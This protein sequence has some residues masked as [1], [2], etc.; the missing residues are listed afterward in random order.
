MS[1]IRTAYRSAVTANTKTTPFTMYLLEVKNDQPGDQE[2]I[3]P[4]V[5]LRQPQ[6][7]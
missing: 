7:L 4:Q 5:E 2:A 3:F 6:L 1:L